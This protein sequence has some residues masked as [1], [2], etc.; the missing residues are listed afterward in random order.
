MK[1]ETVVV[2]THHCIPNGQSLMYTGHSKRVCPMKEKTFQSR[3]Q[4]LTQS[5]FRYKIL[6]REKRNCLHQ[7][8]FLVTTSPPPPRSLSSVLSQQL[9]HLFSRLTIIWFVY[10]SGI[11]SPAL[12]CMLSEDNDRDLRIVPSHRIKCADAP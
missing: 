6:G 8:F 2:F 3:P 5:F 9:E 1:A 12:V 11:L 7:R 4:P 10:L